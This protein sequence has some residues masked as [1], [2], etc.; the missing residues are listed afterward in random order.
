MSRTAPASAGGGSGSAIY[1]DHNATTALLPAAREALCAALDATGNPASV[2]AH[3]RAARA[4]VEKA[5]RAV[6]ARAGARPADIVFTGSATE[7]I[8]GALRSAPQT[9]DVAEIIL[10]SAEHMAALKGAEAAGV[11][12]TTIGVGPEGLVDLDTL[13][14]ALAAADA[15]GRRALVVL[16][17]VNNETGVV[18]PY[19]EVAALVAPTPHLLL[20]DAV[21]LFGRRP[22]DFTSLKADMMAVSGHKIGA[23]S[24]VGALIVGPRAEAIRL[25]PGG[26]QEQGRRSG[27]EAVALIAAFGAAAEAFPGAWDEARLMALRDRVETGLLELAPDRAIFGAGAPRMGHVS[28]F[29]VPGLVS[30]NALMGL[31]LMG[32]SISSGSACASGKVTRSHV[33]DAM[34]VDRALAEG[35]LRVSFGWSSTKADADGFLSAFAEILRRH[36]A[37]KGIAA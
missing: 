3:G 20:V 35:G 9:L 34:G 2:H 5:R 1:L 12:V 27:T 10:S 36:K 13:A 23:A 7:A 26:G 17:A 6:A 25:L 14:R 19:A 29:A 28:N 37:Q 4:L 15:A 8:A 31:D 30:A 22:L 32:V 21:Q 18:Q 16:H 11:P 33:L 24:G